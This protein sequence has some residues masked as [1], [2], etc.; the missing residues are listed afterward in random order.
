MVRGTRVDILLVLG[1][2]ASSWI[3]HGHGS[4]VG[5]KMDRGPIPLDS[6]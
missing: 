4:V 3:M 6:L 2:R 5:L 1:A